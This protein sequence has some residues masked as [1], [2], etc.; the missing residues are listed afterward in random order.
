[1]AIS[2]ICEHNACTGCKACAQVC[3]KQCISFQ[4]DKVGFWYP[5]IDEKSCIECK[6]CQAVCP[7]NNDT[8]KSSGTFYMGWHKDHDV[9]MKSSSG[10]AFSAISSIVFNK[11]GIVIGAEINQSSRDLK[12][13]VIETEQEMD[14]LRFS[15]YYQSDT[16]GIY[17]LVKQYIMSGRLVL[18]SGTACQVAGLKSYLGAFS[19]SDLL[20]TVDVLCHGVASKKAVIKYINSK[21]RNGSVVKAINFRIKDP[22]LGWKN[23][24]GTNVNIRYEDGTRTIEDRLIDPF[25]VGFNHDQILRESCYQCHF[26]GNER[27]SDFTLADYWGVDENEVGRDALREGVSAIEVNTEKAK[28]LL[29]MLSEIMVIREANKNHITAN[30]RSFI[31]PA[32]RP[33]ERSIYYKQFELCDFDTL[34]MSLNK[35]YY[36]K[37]KSKRLIQKMIGEKAFIKLKKWIKK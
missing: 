20:L 35:N 26:T 33:I 24:G 4:E 28:R 5:L 36:R 15:K 21:E 23:G 31:Q 37:V 30:N 19:K 7:I 14:R 2:T 11:G 10:G 17:G 18:F 6:R 16:D 1:M 12:H 27:V 9:L 29:P 25:F 13:V 3:T 22:K 32:P 8:E 34:I